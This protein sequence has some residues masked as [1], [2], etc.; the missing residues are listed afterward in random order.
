MGTESRQADSDWQTAKGSLG[1]DGKAGERGANYWI[2]AQRM[3]LLLG[4]ELP[5]TSSVT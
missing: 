3:G 5:M 1:P 2:D 4:L